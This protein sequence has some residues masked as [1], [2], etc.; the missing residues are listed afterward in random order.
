MRH[1][2]SANR[3]REPKRQRGT[4]DKKG[5]SILEGEA[6]LGQLELTLDDGHPLDTAR[7]FVNGMLI[8]AIIWLA[9]VV[10]Y[11]VALA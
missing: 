8:G 2:A 11:F 1:A 9:V 10:G 6:V 5:G 4:R 3:D 7:G